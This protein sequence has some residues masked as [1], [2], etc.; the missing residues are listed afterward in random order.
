MQQPGSFYVL[1]SH[2]TSDSKHNLTTLDLTK[3]IN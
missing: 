1:D 2:V 3:S